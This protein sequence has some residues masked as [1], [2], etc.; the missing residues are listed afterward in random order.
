LCGKWKDTRST[1]EIVSDIRDQRTLGR[2]V[3]L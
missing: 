3:R 1:K 2:E